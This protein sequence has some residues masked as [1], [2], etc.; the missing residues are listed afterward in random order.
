[1]QDIIQRML[2]CV[3][4]PSIWRKPLFF[5]PWI[6]RKLLLKKHTERTYTDPGLLRSRAWQCACA[7]LFLHT[8]R[9]SGQRWSQRVEACG[10]WRQ[11]GCGRGRL[12]LILKIIDL[13]QQLLQV[14]NCVSKN[15]SPVHLPVANR[16]S[17]LFGQPQGESITSGMHDYNN[18]EVYVP[19]RLKLKFNTK[20]DNW[21]KSCKSTIKP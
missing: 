10:C 14:L 16:D 3:K 2:Y 17:Q 12:K 13:L 21:N 9:Q 19:I 20:T 18:S 1:M 8:R 4:E 11:R 15:R 7:Q 6:R 5:S